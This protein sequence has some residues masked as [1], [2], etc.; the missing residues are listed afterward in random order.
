MKKRIITIYLIGLLIG[1]G[2]GF[3][4]VRNFKKELNK[5]VTY[6]DVAFVTVL[7]FFSWVDVV[8]WTVTELSDSDF[9]DKPIN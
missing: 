7:S 5:P 6:G 4:N 9:W 2:M 3:N 1:W 8:A